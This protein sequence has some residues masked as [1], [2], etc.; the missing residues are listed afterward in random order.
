MIETQKPVYMP[1]LLCKKRSTDFTNS[2]RGRLARTRSTSEFASTSA[3]SRNFGYEH[4]S[5]IGGAAGGN[6]RSSDLT[7]AWFRGQAGSPVVPL[8]RWRIGGE[9]CFLWL[10]SYCIQTMLQWHVNCS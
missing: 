3:T 8:N 4:R 5:H 9:T 2:R 10:V 1:L 7:L 6:A